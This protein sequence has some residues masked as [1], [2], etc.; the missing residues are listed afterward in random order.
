MVLISKVVLYLEE[1][2]F[3]QEVIHHMIQETKVY[4]LMKGYRGEP[5]VDIEYIEDL[6]L[7]VSTMIQE[8]PE[9][10]EMDINPL[11][12]Y[13]K[14]AIAVDARIILED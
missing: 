5:P 10:K 12:A 1:T 7:K 11:F 13:E 6:L 2:E 3:I 9:I 8:N 4:T 14:G